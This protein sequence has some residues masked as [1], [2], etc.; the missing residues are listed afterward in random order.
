MATRILLASTWL[1]IAALA[2]AAPEA[3]AACTIHLV[4]PA[5]GAV[6]VDAPTFTWG[7]VGCSSY[8]VWLSPVSDFATDRTLSS[9]RASP[10]YSMQEENWDGH[11]ATD[12]ASGVFWKVQGRDEAGTTTFSSTRRLRVDPD[13]DDD[14]ASVGGGDCDDT[15]P[16][17]YPGA[18]ETC[19]DGVDQDCDGA[20]PGCFGIPGAGDL[21]ISEMMVNPGNA[22]DI[23]GEWFEV[24]NAGPEAYDLLGFEVADLD[25][26]SF[27]VDANVVV[28]PGGV[29]VLGRSGDEEINGC[30]ALDFVYGGQLPLANPGDEIYLIRADG[31]VID[32][33]EYDAATFPI[34]SGRSASLDPGLLD[35][36]SNDSGAS[37]CLSSA[38]MGCG[39]MG[40]PGEPNDDCP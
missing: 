3:Q 35:A 21:V 36:G 29:V 14:G 23:D 30:V 20:D 6:Q 16:A 17:T 1:G 39:D 31:V 38:D 5:V 7:G 9:W 10:Q 33:V 28:S 18:P 15:D 27:V 37:W 22:A 2:A 40:S 26:D 32:A 12:W 8:R 19:E 34:A 11:V 24:Y 4:T 25:V 13:F